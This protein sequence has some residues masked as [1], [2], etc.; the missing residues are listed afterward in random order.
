MKLLDSRN[1]ALTGGVV[2]YFDGSWHSFGTTGSDGSVSMVLAK[3]NYAFRMTFAN[4]QIEKWQNVGSNPTVVFQTVRVVVELKNSAGTGIGGG[5]AKYYSGSWYAFG[6]TGSDGT[7][8]MELLPINYAFSIDYAHGHQEKWQNVGSNPTVVFQTVRVVVQ[9]KN[10]GGTGINGGVTKY[11]SNAWYGIGT[12][13][14]DGTISIEL[15]PANY[16]FSMD[17]VYGHQEKWQNVG[18]NSN[19]IF[20]TVNV[21]IQLKNSGGTGIGGGVAKY[22]SGSWHYIGTTDSSGQV[23]MELLPINYAFSIDYAHGHNEKWQN[24]GTNPAVTFQTGQVHSSST[25]CTQYYS[26][27]WWTFSQD[28]ELLPGKYLFRFNDKTP[29]TWY[30]VVAATNNTTH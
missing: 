5:V 2:Q 22:Y 12:T 30:T 10:S 18:T 8:S 4:G 21:V 19:V 28:M 29:D 7:L 1:N 24:V 11:Y 3:G 20:Q 23:S 26:G 17:Y 15:L 25:A 9:L 13:G 16:A 6:T 27:G 14:N